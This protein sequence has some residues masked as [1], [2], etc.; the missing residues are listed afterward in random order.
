[1]GKIV[2]T[3]VVKASSAQIFMKA[4]CVP[5]TVLGAENIKLFSLPPYSND[6]NS[7]KTIFILALKELTLI[8][9]TKS[10]SI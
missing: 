3:Y 8:G 4:C 7:N 5:G 2:Q 9:E 1:M 6:S 10:S